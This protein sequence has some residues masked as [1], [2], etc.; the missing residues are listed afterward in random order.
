LILSEVPLL[1]DARVP[2]LDPSFESLIKSNLVFWRRG[3]GRL[4]TLEKKGGVMESGG[5][6]VVEQAIE[7]MSALSISRGDVS[8]AR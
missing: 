2:V 4:E 3:L 8:A 5:E 6:G 1:I 7:G